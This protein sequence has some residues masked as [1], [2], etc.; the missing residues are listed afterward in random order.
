M[1]NGTFCFRREESLSGFVVLV[2]VEDRGG[3][4]GMDV[5]VRWAFDSMVDDF[6]EALSAA[7][8]I[9]AVKTGVLQGL[10]P[11]VVTEETYFRLPILA[12]R[13]ESLP[14]EFKT[15]AV[16]VLPEEIVFGALA[17]KVA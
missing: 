12:L 9:G 17:P 14:V 8:K 3:K 16:G 2:P 6:G 13:V 4:Q 5:R 7:D 10:Y 1:Q 15:Q 11:Q